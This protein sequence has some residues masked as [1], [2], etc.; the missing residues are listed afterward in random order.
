MTENKTHNG[1]SSE[2]DP[3]EPSPGDTAHRA[4][5]PPENCALACCTLWEDSEKQ[6]GF[7]FS[8]SLSLELQ[9]EA[10][11]RLPRRQRAASLPALQLGEAHSLLPSATQGTTVPTQ[12]GC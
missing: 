12:G 6:N 7:L 5:L 10:V 9:Y 2:D 4:T 11:L 8:L 3:A 1:R